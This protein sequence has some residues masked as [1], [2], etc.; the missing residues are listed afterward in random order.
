V[1]L[2]DE[3]GKPIL[4][5]DQLLSLAFDGDFRFKRKE[6]QLRVIVSKL[7][8][9]DLNRALGADP[10]YESIFDRRGL[11]DADGSRI[12][13]TTHMPRHWRN[14]LYEIAGMSEAQQALALG[15]ADISQNPHYQHATIEEKNSS[16]HEL[17]N[18]RNP[19]RKVELFKQGVR[20]GF[21]GGH[22]AQTYRL[23][24]DRSPIES[25]EFLNIHVMAVH[26]TP[27]GICAHDFSKTPCPKHLQ[28]FDSCSHLHRT[29]NPTE[30]KLLRQLI[31][32]Q[33]NNIKRMKHCGCGDEG[34]S[35]W[36]EIEE[37]KLNGMKAA[38]DI[39]VQGIPIRV[40]PKGHKVNE[41]RRRSAVRDDPLE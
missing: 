33:E 2:S 16:L 28:C 4:F 5:K 26:V 12:V 17:I 39:K 22:I 30:E 27:Y 15:R 29:D 18:T 19:L 41:T 6:N 21:V 38:L 13:M 10:K 8:V 24:N 1:A 35:K 34:A 36:L 37:R 3:S 25:E 31:D 23:L 20:E 14:T 32:R 11:K 40:F 7:D 9:V